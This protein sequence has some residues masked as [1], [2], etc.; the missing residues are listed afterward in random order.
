MLTPRAG[1]HPRCD[2]FN[3]HSRRR[4]NPIV[5]D[6]VVLYRRRPCRTALQSGRAG[7]STERA[8]RPPERDAV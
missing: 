3:L 4:R 5:S 7:V 2:A 8:R 6:P 1:S